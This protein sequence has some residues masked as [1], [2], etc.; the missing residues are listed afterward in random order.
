[1][2]VT[3][4]IRFQC[5]K[6]RVRLRWGR[7]P[8]VK[9][10]TETKKF[11]LHEKLPQRNNELVQKIVGKT[12]AS[13]CNGESPI[14]EMAGWPNGMDPPIDWRELSN[15]MATHEKCLE[16]KMDGN[17]Q[18]VRPVGRDIWPRNASVSWVV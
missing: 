9:F 15:G 17:W 10:R 4:G 18:N 12:V 8:T 3:V 14:G 13:Y 11:S 16:G 5:S 1:M 7:R 6:R 2:T